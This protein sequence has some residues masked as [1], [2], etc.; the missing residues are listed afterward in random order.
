[1]TNRA[2]NSNFTKGFQALMPLWIAAAPVAIAYAYTAQQVGLSGVETQ[3]MSLIVFSAAT[4]VSIL[5]ALSSGGSFLSYAF[6]GVLLNAHYLLYAVALTRR[7]RLRWSQRPL[8]AFLLSD[9]VYAITEASG[10]EATL[11]FFL[12][13]GTSMY[14]AWNLFTALGTLLHPL[15]S[16][17]SWMRFDFGV[18]LI[19]FA[20]LIASLKTRTH[21]VVGA[22][23]LLIALLSL[24]AGLGSMTL[25]VTGVA[26][27]ALGTWLTR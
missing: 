25:I 12:G 22:V 9:G 14:V 24:Q 6:N 23:A 2:P 19:F 17:F 4:Q 20:L 15:L 11:S 16:R 8:A 27:A 10:E 21:Y 13:A 18:A 26:G 3:L 1:M 7:F 5:Q